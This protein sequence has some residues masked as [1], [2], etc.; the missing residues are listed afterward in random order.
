MV[1]V[2]MRTKFWLGSLRRRDYFEDAEVGGEIML[3]IYLK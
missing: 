1:V 3:K 2:K